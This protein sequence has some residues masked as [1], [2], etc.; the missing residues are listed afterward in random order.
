M[1]WQEFEE[2]RSMVKYRLSGH[3]SVTTYA[4]T[5]FDT[6]CVLYLAEAPLRITEH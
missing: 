1:G 3:P 6:G 5:H 4:M 2:H